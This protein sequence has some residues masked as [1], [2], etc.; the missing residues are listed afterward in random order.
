MYKMNLYQFFTLLT[1]DSLK[2]S[3]KSSVEIYYQCQSND[4]H[5]S[6]LIISNLFVIKILLFVIQ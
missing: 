3:G 2:T 4:Y 5:A 6:A 1:P